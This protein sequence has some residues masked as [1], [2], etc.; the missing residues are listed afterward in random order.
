MNFLSD[1]DN[2]RHSRNSNFASYLQ[3]KDSKM[4]VKYLWNNAAHSV[5]D[6]INTIKKIRDPHSKVSEIRYLIFLE[7]VNVLHR[8]KIRQ[9]KLWHF[10]EKE[11]LARPRT[12]LKHFSKP[13]LSVHVRFRQPL[14]TIIIFECVSQM[15]YDDWFRTNKNRIDKLCKLRLLK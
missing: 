5:K 3:E 6:V 1:A 12:L 14:T 13:W 10:Q 15:F 7:Y 2:I 4:I 11:R 8:I 9:V